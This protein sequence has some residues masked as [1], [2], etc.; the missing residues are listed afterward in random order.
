MYLLDTNILIYFLNGNKKVLNFLN[1]LC[2]E[3]FSISIITRLEVL[4]G[5]CKEKKSDIELKKILDE[6]NNVPLDK[7]IVD[8]AVN[9]YLTSSKKLK[10]KDLSIAATAKIAKKILITA[11][12][13]FEKLEGVSVKIYKM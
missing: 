10:F 8:E 3:Q 13:D 2:Q 5:Q 12:R 6:C 1:D 11:D 7:K 9:L 4:L